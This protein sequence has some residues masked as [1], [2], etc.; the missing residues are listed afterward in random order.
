LAIGIAADYGYNKLLELAGANLALAEANLAVWL[1]SQDSALTAEK[2]ARLASFVMH[3]LKAGGRLAFHKTATKG[4]F[5]AF[6]IKR[7]GT[8]SKAPAPKTTEV[9]GQRIQWKLGDGV[10]NKDHHDWHKIFGAKKPTLDEVKPYVEKAVQ[11]GTWIERGPAYD[12]KLREVTGTKVELVHEAY[13]YKI[14]VSGIKTFD[15]EIIIRN[16][17]VDR[18]INKFAKN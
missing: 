14:W 13:G 5:K 11:G 7:Q 1:Q 3:T 10:V 17:A 9:P 2:S 8:K 18:G 6:Q 12:P 16:A 15:N 4:F